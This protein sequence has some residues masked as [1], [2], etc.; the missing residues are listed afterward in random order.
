MKHRDMIRSSSHEFPDSDMKLK[1]TL[2]KL[3]MSTIWRRNFHE[4]ENFQNTQGFMV[5]VNFVNGGGCVCRLLSHDD[6]M[7]KEVV[8]PQNCKMTHS[9]S[10]KTGIFWY[11]SRG[12]LVTFSDIWD[13]ASCENSYRLLAINYYLNEYA[14]ET[15]I[16]SG[17]H[18]KCSSLMSTI[19]ANHSCF[20]C[21]VLLI[22]AYCTQQNFS[23]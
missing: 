4:V 17:L 8:F 13:C 19:V 22:L 20:S 9:S 23:V 7:L 11:L 18:A 21:T 14:S 15:C 2:G 1:L 12:L 16:F 5:H 3:K 10:P 6:E